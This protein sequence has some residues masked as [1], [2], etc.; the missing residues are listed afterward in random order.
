ME[1]EK[2]GGC[3]YSNSTEVADAICTHLSN[4]VIDRDNRMLEH[5]RLQNEKIDKHNEKVIDM[6][7]ELKDGMIAQKT[8]FEKEIGDIKT[9]ITW[10]KQRS[11]K[12]TV[13]KR[14]ALAV[15]ISLIVFAIITLV[16]KILGYL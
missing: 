9:D 3:I 8:T 6:L 14:I 12:A 1:K 15:G 10:L 7:T 13:R 11:S 2:N 4:I 5:N 16:L